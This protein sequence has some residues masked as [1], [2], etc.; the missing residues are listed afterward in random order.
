[1]DI[2]IITTFVKMVFLQTVQILLGDTNTYIY[3]YLMLQ[4]SY[5]FSGRAI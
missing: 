4:M 2:E 3:M 1:M 5:I